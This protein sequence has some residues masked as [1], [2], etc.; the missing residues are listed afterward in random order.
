MFIRV[1]TE[2]PTEMTDKIRDAFDSWAY[3][4]KP[5]AGW[6][7][8][9]GVLVRCSLWSGWVFWEGVLSGCS[10]WVF[11]V[12]W[13]PGLHTTHISGQEL[14]TQDRLI[15]TPMRTPPYPTLT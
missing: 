2:V 7:F 10:R 13:A 12:F 8:R 11:L 5:K 1:V 4:L 9:Q 3:R 14:R 6:G 15:T